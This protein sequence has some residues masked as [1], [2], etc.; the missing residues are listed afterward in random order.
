[1]ARPELS[2]AIGRSMKWCIHFNTQF[3]NFFKS[4]NIH[5]LCDPPITHLDTYSR[6]IKTY[7]HTKTGARI[8]IG[9]LLMKLKPGNNRS[10]LCLTFCFLLCSSP[11]QKTRNKIASARVAFLPKLIQ[12]TFQSFVSGRLAG[13]LSIWGAHNS[14]T[15]TPADPQH[16]CVAGRAPPLL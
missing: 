1:M 2:Y 14:V 5:P 11:S 13:H 15:R 8:L 10:S 6:E 7:V 12:V 9:A 16:P 4:L 3:G